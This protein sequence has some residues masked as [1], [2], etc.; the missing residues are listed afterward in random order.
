M[1]YIGERAGQS[2]GFF[3]GA[4]SKAVS[5]SLQTGKGS[6]FIIEGDEYD[7]CF[8]AKRPKFFYYNPHS[9][10]VTN[11]E[12]DHGDIYSHL[13]E[14]TE[15]FCS[16]VKKI[17]A[18]GWLALC[19]HS[20]PLKK[21][22]KVSKAQIITYGLNQGDF[23][24]KN[25]QIGPQGQTF[26]L[27]HKTE[28]YSCSLPLLGEHNALNSAGVFALSYKLGWPVEKILLGLKTFKGVKRRLEFKGRLKEAFIYED[29]AHHPTEVRSG[30]SALREAYPHKK[31]L[32]LFE[33]R[34]FTSRLNVFQKDYAQAFDKADTIFI[35]KA[36]NTSKISLERRF[37]SSKLA[38]DLCQKGKSAFYYES[39]VDME[40]AL[41]KELNR[42]TVAVFMSSGAFGPLLGNITQQLSE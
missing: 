42:E 36:Y 1:S 38:R 22:V 15:L 12:F 32:A 10:L 17:P 31:L 35:A 8:F 39:F 14:I 41:Y 24:I 6:W 34:S 27:C 25:R 7:S 28:T 9:A 20:K 33:P 3:F 11:I 37:S 40:E 4:L 5:S 16:F 23:A 29:F 19:A 26:D 18:R 2:P 30:L 13:D 21:L